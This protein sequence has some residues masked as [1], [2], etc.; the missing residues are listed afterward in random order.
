MEV[1][2][3][4]KVSAHWI[5]LLGLCSFVFFDLHVHSYFPPLQ[6]EKDN[7]HTVNTTG[8]CIYSEEHTTLLTGKTGLVNDVGLGDT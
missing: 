6:T 5:K 3:V 4:S 8:L 7:K 1:Q 2:E